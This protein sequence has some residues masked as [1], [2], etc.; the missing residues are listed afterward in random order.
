MRQYTLSFK[1]AIGLFGG[2][3]PSTAIFKGTE[4]RYAIE[5]ERLNRQKHAISCFPTGSITACLEYCDVELADLEKIVLP[6]VPKLRTKILRHNID[7]CYNSSSLLRT[8]YNLN[9][10]LKEIAIARY[11]PIESI[12]RNLREEFGEPLPPIELKSHHH[13]HAASAFHLSNLDKA[14][15]LTIDGRGEYDSTVVWK[16]TET[17]LERVKTYK[18]PNSLGHFFGAITEYL[19]YRAFNGEG[20]IMGLA[21]YGN[22]N[23]EIK[24]QLRELID[25][26]ADYDVTNIT[27]MGSIPR[28]TRRLEKH[29]GRERSLSEEFTQWEKDLAYVAQ[30]LLEET[31]EN[32]VETYCDNLNVDN[33]ALAGGVALNCKMN[34]QV[35]EMDCVDDLFIQPVAHDAGLALGAPL[36]NHSPKDVQPMADV[37]W[38]SEFTGDD[39]EALLKNNKIRYTTPENLERTI[40]EEIASGSLVGWFQGKMEMGPR[41]L[42]HRSILADPRDAES[43][44]R[45]N[46]YVKNR[47]GWRPFAPSILEEK[48]GEYLVNN[49]G[50]R[51]MIKTF[52]TRKENRS[53]LE[54]V[55]HPGD[56][57]TRPQTVTP[58]HNDRYYRLISEF[59][60][61]TG[62][63]ALLNTSFNDHGEP[64]IHT[65]KEAIKGFYGMGL[66]ILVLEDFVIRK[67]TPQ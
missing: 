59:E 1:P 49:E 28:G 61:I 37:Y 63:P 36:L 51:Y 60:D 10:E 48:A 53:D 29:F 21:P 3:D 9:E 66:D 42:G 33:V 24:S 50:S 47:E 25:T 31:V 23:P 11:F 54:A 26:S 18:F 8:A 35:M 46:R 15:V 57:T 56:G 16:G 7:Q 13:C 40:A 39:I 58:E 2:H 52:E 5:E 67:E 62:V 14:L 12:K 55:L 6:Y 17:G 20:K 34:K 64:I 19:G 32:V 65:P 45:V 41:A 38:G 30:S 44:D 4:L 22:P 27:E 43:R